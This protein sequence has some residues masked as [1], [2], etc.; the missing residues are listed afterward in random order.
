L[1][2]A[3]AINGRFLTQRTTGV[4]R[5]AR[6]IVHALDELDRPDL[7]LELICPRDA[8]RLPGLTRIR[9]TFR[10]VGGGQAWEQLQLPWLAAGRP[11]LCL[12]NLAPVA[13]SRR[14]V[15]IHDAAAFDAPGGY[16]RA[17]LAWYRFVQRALAA[18][19]AQLITVSQFSR[20][21]L[22][23]ALHVEPGQIAVVGEAADHVD[24]I[25]PDLSLVE[26][27][28]LRGRHFVLAIG[29]LHP[30]KNVGTLEQAMQDPRLADVELV[31]A[32]GRSPSVF[33]DGA[34]ASGGKNVHY[35][36]YASDE[37]LAGLLRSATLFVFPSLYEG[38]GLPPLE[39]MRLGCPVLAST[40]AA[41][42]EVC[43]RDA[44]E[45]FD[46]DDPVRLAG[47]IADLVA[48]DAKRAR[49][50]AAGHRRAS[51]TQWR[52]EA[53]AL[54]DVLRAPGQRLPTNA[55]R[56]VQD[57]DAPPMRQSSR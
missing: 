56:R 37:Q 50:I 28:G 23:R 29:S 54:L 33:R 44:A 32:G 3:I 53:Q 39:A 48:S 27:L 10:G 30:N 8:E 42:P 55:T 6:E 40:A 1:S 15:V 52:G 51:R 57:H 9:Q 12:C 21:R 17:F 41:I 31:V 7:A 26:G 2:A 4:Q 16:G 18:S 25:Q 45:Y 47:A 38:F 5:F 13:G 35:T 34:R 20:Q 46:P 19:G 24:R 22:A 36:G 43:G 11:L 14:A 49:L